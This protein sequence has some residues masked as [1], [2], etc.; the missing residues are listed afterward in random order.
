[1]SES[2]IGAGGEES[3]ALLLL[4]EPVA[5]GADEPA[6]SGSEGVSQTETSSLCVHLALVDLSDLLS[7]ESLVGE[8]LG[9]HGGEVAEDL[10]GE[11]LVDLKDSDVFHLE[12][13]G[14]EALLGAVG[15]AEQ[16]LFVEERS[17]ELD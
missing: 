16:Q 13:H 7:V 1:M 12:V 8:G 17:D 14:V 6:S 3:E 10:S 11:G 4:L 2:A 5:G 9:V 15:G